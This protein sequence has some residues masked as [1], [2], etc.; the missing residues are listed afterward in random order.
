MNAQHLAGVGPHADDDIHVANAI[1]DK[2][3][4]VVTPVASLLG[5]VT[6]ALRFNGPSACWAPPDARP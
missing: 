6:V 4:A 2:K 1:D 3:T 5:A